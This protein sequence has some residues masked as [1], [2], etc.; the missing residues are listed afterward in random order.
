MTPIIFHDEVFDA[1]IHLLAPCESADL[2]KYIRNVTGENYDPGEYKA[3]SFYC[4]KKVVLAIELPW[5]G[6][7]R[8]I[9]LLAHECAHATFHIL[10]GCDIAIVPDVEE[11]FALLHESILRRCLLALA[12]EERQKE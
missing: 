11:V 8:E 1:E 3:I 2:Q 6:T 10:H 5:T 12:L 9:A 4:A 7:Y